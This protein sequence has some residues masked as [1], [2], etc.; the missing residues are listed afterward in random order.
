MRFL[1]TR[2]HGVPVDFLRHAIDR[3]QSLVGTRLA[4]LT[5]FT[6]VLTAWAP[7]ERAHA[8]W[9]IVQEGVR[10]PDVGPTPLSRRRR[11]LH[12]ALRLRDADVPVWRSSLTERFKQLMV[13]KDV[14][15]EPTT[16]Q[17]MEMAW[18]RGVQRLAAYLEARLA[19]LQTP[20]D[21]E[22][23]RPT[24]HE[25]RDFADAHFEGWQVSADA[26]DG[27][28]SVLRRPS[29]GAQPFF[30]NLFVT[31]VFMR[32]RAVYRRIT[33]RLVTA[34]AD[35]VGFYTARGFTGKTPQRTY[36]PVHALW[37]CRAEQVKPSHPGRPAV[38][39]LW[40]P[41]P[42]RAGEQ[43]HFASE[44]VDENITAERDWVDV[45]IDHHGIAR[46]RLIFGNRLPVSGL[47]IRVRFDEG[48]LPDVVWWYA[49]QNERERYEQPPAGDRH[50]LA[51]TGRDLQH[52]FT[53]QVCQPRESYGLAFNW[54]TA[55]ATPRA[56]DRMEVDKGPEAGGALPRRPL[57]Q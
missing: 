16:T 31:T 38:T 51:I 46:G 39:R 1:G 3:P 9:R 18:R 30:V 47:T 32:R 52:T 12:A 50:F 20:M 17:P 13:L 4:P 26:H 53:E 11:A 22:P 56:Y 19:V 6:S 8:L 41:A 49:E 48:H 29:R 44:V 54:P 35:G 23:Y 40:F 21:W 2:D 27:V 55:R 45:D 33:E 14:F 42:L 37:G 25:R 36:E 57:F 24:E 34:Q 15:N 28:E 7:D 10:D 5:A 43:A